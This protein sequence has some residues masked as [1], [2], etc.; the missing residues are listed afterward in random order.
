MAADQLR[1]RYPD[2][3]R[4]VDTL[5]EKRKLWDVTGMGIPQFLALNKHEH[6]E[7][8]EAAANIRMPYIIRDAGR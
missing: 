2:I 7:L 8:Y 5:T 4:E 3:W 6:K 1:A